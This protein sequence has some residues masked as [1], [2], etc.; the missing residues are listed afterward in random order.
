M[1]SR[2]TM[3]MGWILMRRKGNGTTASRSPPTREGWN[4]EESK[5]TIK[6]PQ[7]SGDFA[8]GVTDVV[9]DGRFSSPGREDGSESLAKIWVEMRSFC[10]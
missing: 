2:V 8:G 10:V 9:S 5:K 3:T 6:S 7:R 4:L 1:L